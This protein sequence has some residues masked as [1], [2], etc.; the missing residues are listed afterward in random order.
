MTLICGRLQVRFLRR[1]SLFLQSQGSPWHSRRASLLSGIHHGIRRSQKFKRG[2]NVRRQEQREKP[3]IDVF[4]ENA[5]E[6]A[7]MG[8]SSIT[9]TGKGGSVRG[10]KPG[11]EEPRGGFRLIKEE[12]NMKPKGGDPNKRKMPENPF[13]RKRI[14]AEEE[15]KLLK[16]KLRAGRALQ[17][18]KA[19]AKQTNYNG[20]MNKDGAWGET[21]ARSKGFRRDSE[22]RA[23][24]TVK[25]AENASDGARLG[26]PN[27]NQTGGHQSLSRRRD[28]LRAGRRYEEDVSGRARSEPAWASPTVPEDRPSSKSGAW[29]EKEPWASPTREQQPDSR[30]SL[31]ETDDAGP[32]AEGR[33]GQTY[34][35]GRQEYST[36]KAFAYAPIKSTPRT[37]AASVFL[38]GYSAVLEA[39][40]ASRRQLYKLYMMKG[41][42]RRQDAEDEHIT[43]LAKREGIPISNVDV[44]QQSLLDRMAGGRPHNGVVLEASPLPM[45]RLVGLGSCSTTAY[46][47]QMAVQSA[48]EKSING[49]AGSVHYKSYRGRR[50]LVVLVDGVQDEGNVGAIIRSACF[51]GA[52]AVVVGQRSTAPVKAVAAKAAAGAAETMILYTTS[53]VEKFVTESR[54]NGWQTYA[55]AVQ[56]IKDKSF[57]LYRFEQKEDPLQRHPCLVIVGNEGAGLS[58]AVRRAAEFEIEIPNSMEPQHTVDSLNVS[59]AAGILLNAFIRPR[60][61]SRAPN[62]DKALF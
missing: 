32:R 24:R 46:K 54:I 50:P 5:V 15:L 60:T 29:D 30:P 31:G 39:I 42:G 47:V 9:P 56:A 27:R 55:T 4:D 59:V 17:R 37:T 23:E 8:D 53:D 11:N 13:E 58:W 10:L 21:P 36:G 43:A 28:S 33:E 51:F 7:I 34:R 25:A 19:M 49:T 18:S 45:K 40:R 1:P 48:E 57:E 61:H 12:R 38:Y 3:Q 44:M 22:P 52:H 16:D 2:R 41:E 14:A 62:T 26:R 6:M 20:K 35:D